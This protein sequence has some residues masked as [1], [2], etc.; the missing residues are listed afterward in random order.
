MMAR[1]RALASTAALLAAAVLA[2]CSS[3][4]AKPKP[5][6]LQTLAASAP[7]MEVAWRQRVGRID[8]PLAVATQ[9]GVYTLASGDGTVLA[10]DPAT[11]RELWRG[12]AGAPLSAGVGSDGRTAAVVT[13]AGDLVVMSQGQPLWRKPLGLS[14]ITAPLVAGERVFVLAVDRSV[15]AFDALDGRKLWSV[16]RPSD[17]L[18]LAQAGVL[19]PYQDT[20]LVGQG[21]RLVALDPLR[22]SVRWEQPLATP[23]GTNEVERLADLVG[24]SARDGDTVCARAFQAAVGCVNAQRGALA[25]TRVVGGLNGVAV[26]AGRLL[27]ADASDRISTWSAAT[28]EPGWT[29]EALRYRGLSAPVV[30]G[31]DVIFGDDDGL[32]HALSLDDGR[33]VS[34][35][36]T[37]GGRLA[38]SSAAL[39][40]TAL[41][42]TPSGGV[43]AL[44]AR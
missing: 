20:L 12:Q 22:G 37:E 27:A 17:P 26:G 43:L 41:F 42:V 33:L 10:L 13:Q 1:R 34:R 28:G 14:V 21:T 5:T 3:T 38:A 31:R 19:L 11:G 15:Q 32:L 16:Q 2:A 6:P 39:A 8:F 36:A 23:R 24:P 40:G 29:S 30:L 44:R 25:W 7:A 18:T 35:I 4:P 9:G